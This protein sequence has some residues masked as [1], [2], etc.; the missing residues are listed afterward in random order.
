VLADLARGLVPALKE[1][2]F[3]ALHELLPTDPAPPAPQ[4][5]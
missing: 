4:D 5:G 1:T 2:V 3:K